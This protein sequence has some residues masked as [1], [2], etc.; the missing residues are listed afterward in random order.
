MNKKQKT[1]LAGY[2]LIGFIS[3]LVVGVTLTARLIGF[4]IP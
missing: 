3:G 1:N 2:T 4:P